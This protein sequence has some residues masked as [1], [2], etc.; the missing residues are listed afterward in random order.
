M[1][2]IALLGFVGNVFT[3]GSL[4]T[5]KRYERRNKIEDKAS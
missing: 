1:K 2:Q 5:I 4:A 3:N